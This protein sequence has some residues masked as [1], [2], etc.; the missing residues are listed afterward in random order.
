MRSRRTVESTKLGSTAENTTRLLDQFGQS[1]FNV[2]MTE[3]LALCG[4]WNSEKQGEWGSPA[5]IIIV[6]EREL[7]KET[8]GRDVAGTCED[9]GSVSR[10]CHASATR[11]WRT[12][13]TADENNEHRQHAPKTSTL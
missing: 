8:E 4:S 2:T 11:R 5:R 6:K 12:K 10:D 7:T 1:V 9:K 3:R 13:S